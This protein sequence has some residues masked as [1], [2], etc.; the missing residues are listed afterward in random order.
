VQHHAARV[1]D[2]LAAPVARQAG[3]V[4][5][6]PGLVQHAH[7]G[8]CEVG[9]VVARGDAYIVGGAAGEGM[10]RDVEPAVAEVEAQ[11]PGHLDAQHALR[12]DRERP[13]SGSAS[14]AVFWRAVTR[15]SIAGRKA[16]N[17]ANSASMRAERPPGSYSS[18]SASYK[19]RPSAAALASPTRL[20][21]VTTSVKVG[22]SALKSAFFLASRHAI[23]QAEVARVR[24][25]DQVRR[26][27]RGVD[28]GVTH[29]A[30]V[31]GT[32]D[33][34]GA[35]AL[36][37]ARQEIAHVG[38]HHQLVRDHAQGGELVGA[39]LAR[40]LGHHG[41]AVPVQDRTRA[42]DRAH[43]A[44]AALELGVGIVAIMS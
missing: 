30:Q 43:A 7:Q 35:P 22:S 26:Q 24:G 4:E 25:L 29:L 37:G 19:G 33:I 12:L 40:A 44:E 5:R 32:P 36:L 39:I 3:L 10:G 41:R 23:S 38:G 9:F 28:P 34:E 31:R 16:F 13:S 18:S 17:S 6:M 15:C 2:R 1:A 42:I 8:A 20:V 27:R 21:S 11:G 14:P